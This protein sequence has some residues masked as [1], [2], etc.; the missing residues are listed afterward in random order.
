[1]PGPR[2][3]SLDEVNELVPRLA[4]VF[5][6]VDEIKEALRVLHI[7]LNALELIWGRALRESTN[8]DH[9]EFTSYVTEMKTLEDEVEKL[10][11]GIAKLSGQVKS[12]DPPLVDFYGVRDGHLVLWCW[13]R[14]EERI[15]HWHH[16]D[17]GFAS[18]QHV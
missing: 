13:T 14:G 3:Y 4:E 10:T 17:T 6:R 8:P 7:R 15:E 5:A 9:G 1:M 11:Q 12:V 2:V 18:R 16:V